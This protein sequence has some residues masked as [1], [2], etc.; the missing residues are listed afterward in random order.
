MYWLKT[1]AVDHYNPGDR[2]YLDQAVVRQQTAG[3]GRTHW[4]NHIRDATADEPKFPFGIRNHWPV[5]NEI[6]DDFKCSDP[7]D[8]VA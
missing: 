6:F 8:A 5:V 2:L 7:G 3:M 1:P 4:V